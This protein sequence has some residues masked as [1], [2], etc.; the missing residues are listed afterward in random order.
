MLLLLLLQMS[1]IFSYFM[2][3]T[4]YIHRNDDDVSFV[5]DQHAEL[6]FYNASSLKKP[7]VGRHVAPLRQIILI[8]SQPVFALIP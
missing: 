5:Q 7:S 3:R 2:V 8:P 4:S 1:N 6:D